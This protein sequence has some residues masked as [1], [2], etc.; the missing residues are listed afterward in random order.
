MSGKLTIDL[1]STVQ[2]LVE[3]H[4]EFDKELNVLFVYYQQVCDSVNSETLWDSY[5]EQYHR[6]T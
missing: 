1:I 3:K 2:R 4:C 5:K 6:A